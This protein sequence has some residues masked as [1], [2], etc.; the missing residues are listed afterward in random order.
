MSM[1]TKGFCCQLVI[2]KN[3]Q[4]YAYLS[5]L[6]HVIRFIVQLLDNA[7]EPRGDLAAISQRHL[8]ISNDIYL[9]RCF[10]RLYLADRVELLHARAGL[11]EPLDNLAFGNTYAQHD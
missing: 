2:C 8:C 11:Y 7:I 1:S 10:I 4:V 3:L 5:N 6:S 9:D